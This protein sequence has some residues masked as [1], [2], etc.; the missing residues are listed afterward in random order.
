MGPAGLVGPRASGQLLSYLGP[1][2]CSPLSEL[3]PFFKEGLLKPGLKALVL[4]RLPFTLHVE[5]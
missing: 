5:M 3:I 2:F 1:D 4:A